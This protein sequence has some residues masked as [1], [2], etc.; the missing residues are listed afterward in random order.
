[1]SEELDGHL[2]EVREVTPDQNTNRQIWARSLDEN[3]LP[4]IKLFDGTHSKLP[5]KRII[6]GPSRDQRDRMRNVRKLVGRNIQVVRS[7][8]PYVG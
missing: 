3:I 2:L 5:I 1:M 8:T 4:Y 6:V 7:E